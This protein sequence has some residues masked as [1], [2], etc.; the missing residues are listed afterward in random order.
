M[1]LTIAQKS[2]ISGFPKP[3]ELIEITGT[4]GLEAQDRALLNTLYKLAH[5]SGDIGKP[6]ARWS[7]PMA[8]LNPGTH[9][10]LERV[11][12]SL[13]RLMGVQVAVTFNDETGAEKVLQ[14]VLFSHFITPKTGPGDLVFGIPEELRAILARSGRWGR[15]QAEIVHAMS[16]K[17]AIALYELLRL[18]ANM[19]NC[20]EIFTL[21]RFREL[22]GV[23]PGTYAD[24]T[25]F[26]RKV[27][28]PALLEVNGLSELA[29]NIKLIRAHARAPVESVLIGWEK[30]TAEQNREAYRELQRSKLG[31]K[32]RLRGEVETLT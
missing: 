11:R 26:L 21:D 28:E 30:K 5:D 6:G 15:I 31:R 25:N 10:G 12:V 16:S 18:R 7:I 22:L 9:K 23:P 20:T 19:D 3:A 1:A 27:I 14:T 13:S 29:C 2:N 32:A 8:D 17:Y 4:S 24:G